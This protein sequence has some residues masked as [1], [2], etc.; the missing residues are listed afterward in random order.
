MRFF[1]IDMPWSNKD[2]SHLQMVQ[3]V[4]HH[5]FLHKMVVTQEVIVLLCLETVFKLLLQKQSF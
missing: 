3:K 1:S 2:E 4:R 5:L